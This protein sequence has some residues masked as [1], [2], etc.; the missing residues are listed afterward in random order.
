MRD[1]WVLTVSGTRHQAVWWLVALPMAPDGANPQADLRGGLA[2]KAIVRRRVKDPFGG[3]NRLRRSQQHEGKRS[4]AVVVGL[5]PGDKRQVLCKRKPLHEPSTIAVDMD[6]FRACHV[7]R[8]VQLGDVGR[9]RRGEKPMVL[10]LGRN[11]SVEVD[12]SCLPYVIYPG[13]SEPDHSLGRDQPGGAP[14]EAPWV[15]AGRAT[16]S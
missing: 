10:Q 15:L 3:V 4:V 8:V 14:I 5:V 16:C 12:H 13:E 1:P 7:R 6:D 2:Q 9:E 11:W